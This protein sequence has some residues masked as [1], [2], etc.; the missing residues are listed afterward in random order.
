M[1]D[2]RFDLMALVNRELKV[3]FLKWLRGMLLRLWN[4]CHQ[5]ISLGVALLELGTTTNAPP[6]TLAIFRSDR[7]EP[8][9]EMQQIETLRG[10]LWE[11]LCSD[12]T[13]LTIVPLELA[14]T[15]T[16]QHITP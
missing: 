6:L 5:I 10:T 11:R 13:V 9:R 16:V 2:E 7:Q 12:Q 4:S 1:Q 3:L 15:V 8:V 14:T